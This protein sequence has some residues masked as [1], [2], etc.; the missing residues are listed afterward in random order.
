MLANSNEQF[1]EKPKQEDYHTHTRGA[2]IPKIR[3]DSVV[4]QL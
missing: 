1:Y 3:Q 2:A 4:Q